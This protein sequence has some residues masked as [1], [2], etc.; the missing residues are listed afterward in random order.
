MSRNIN[1]KSIGM[2]QKSVTGSCNPH[3]HQQSSDRVFS[4][5]TCPLI[6][7]MTVCVSS[8]ARAHVIQ[9]RG[10]YHGDGPPSSDDSCHSPTV[11]PPSTID[12]SSIMERYHRRRRCSHTSLRRSPTMVTLHVTRFVECRWWNDGWTVKTVVT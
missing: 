5:I 8:R 1:I 12:K 6:D 2:V 3:L 10:R 7:R 9:I 4:T 11:I